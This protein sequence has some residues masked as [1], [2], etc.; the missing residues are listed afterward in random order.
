MNKDYLGQIV[1]VKMDRPL[2]IGSAK[3]VRRP[4][5]ENIIWL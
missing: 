4:L 5:W 2:R 3:N 1:K